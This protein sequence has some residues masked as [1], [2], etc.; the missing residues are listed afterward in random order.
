MLCISK[1]KKLS[2]SLREP[3]GQDEVSLVQWE[4]GIGAKRG[5]RGRGSL[6]SSDCNRCLARHRQVTLYQ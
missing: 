6:N 3:V 4:L 5:G 1:G 2:L